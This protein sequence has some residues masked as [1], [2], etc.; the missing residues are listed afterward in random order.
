M[1]ADESPGDVHNFDELWRAALRFYE[2]ETGKDLL[3]LPDA[4]GFPSRPSSADEVIEII[5]ARSESFKAFRDKGRK[6]LTVLKPIV[7]FVRLF[8]DAGAEAAGASVSTNSLSR[9]TIV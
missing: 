9:L 8:I 6:L 2:K 5:K 4:A 3:Q 7:H 1:A